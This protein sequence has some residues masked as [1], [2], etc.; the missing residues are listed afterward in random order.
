MFYMAKYMT[1]KILLLTQFNDKH[2]LLFINSHFPLFI[3]KRTMNVSTCVRDI[4]PIL[5]LIVDHSSSIY[6]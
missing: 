1:G 5:T 6:H 2:Y 4:V 3:A